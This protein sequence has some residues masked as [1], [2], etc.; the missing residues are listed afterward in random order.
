MEQKKIHM[1]L[2]DTLNMI[3]DGTRVRINTVY[4]QAT[5]AE[6]FLAQ[7][8]DLLNRDESGN[9]IL[10]ASVNRMYA[11]P[12]KVPNRQSKKMEDVAVLVIFIED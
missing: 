3:S 2:K 7:V 12:K 10:E 11:A 8:E 1:K 4:P 9:E 6:G 5:V